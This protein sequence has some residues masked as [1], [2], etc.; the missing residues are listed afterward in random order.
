VVANLRVKL[1]EKGISHRGA[2]RLAGIDESDACRVLA[3]G[4]A[5]PRT[6]RKLF[7]AFKVNEYK[8][9]STAERTTAL[10]FEIQAAAER[11]ADLLGEL[12]ALSG[13]RNYGN[14]KGKT[15][16]RDRVRTKPARQR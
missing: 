1:A 11:V 15:K 14:G 3:F 16:Q 13:D 6:L 9:L 7:E 12:A 5:T 4:E 2:G 10:L 8:K